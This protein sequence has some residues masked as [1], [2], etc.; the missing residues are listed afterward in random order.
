MNTPSHHRV[1]HG[2]NRYCIDKNYGGTLIIFDRI[3][4]TFEAEK[5][6]VVYGLVHPLDSWGPIHSQVCTCRI[7]SLIHSQVRPSWSWLYGS[8]IYNYLCNQCL[9]PLKL[10]VWIP[11]MVKCTRYNIMWKSLSVTCDGSVVFSG[12]CGFLHQWNWPPQYTSNV[13]HHSPNPINSDVSGWQSTK[14][15]NKLQEI[16]YGLITLKKTI[17]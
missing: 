11:L 1:H 17:P 16:I 8:W 12:Y 3:F 13:N 4:G 7:W 9:S 10:W 2:R 15:M 6:E 14:Q 5:E